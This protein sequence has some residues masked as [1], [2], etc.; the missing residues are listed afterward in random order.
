MVAQEISQVVAIT[1]ASSTG[2]SRT[3]EAAFLDGAGRE[4]RLGVDQIRV[5]ALDAEHGRERRYVGLS[6]KD[7]P[8]GT[9]SLA[10]P[11]SRSAPR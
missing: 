5:R 4:N 7:M 2:A 11:S 3:G 6:E 10:R 8:A 9:A 1:S